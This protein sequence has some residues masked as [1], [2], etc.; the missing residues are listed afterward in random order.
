MS[1]VS[2]VYFEISPI[3]SGIN[4]ISTRV[5]TDRPLNGDRVVVIRR[6]VLLAGGHSMTLRRLSA[7]GDV[8]DSCWSWLFL[9]VIFVF[10]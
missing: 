4:D 9:T 2:R 10:N 5:G 7:V 8:V 1:S 6:G 3:V